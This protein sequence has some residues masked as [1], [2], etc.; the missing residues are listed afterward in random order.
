M[1][2]H[3]SPNARSIPD[4]PQALDA[5]CGSNRRRSSWRAHVSAAKTELDARTN[6]EA[7]RSQRHNKIFVDS[8]LGGVAAVFPSLRSISILCVVA[9]SARLN[10]GV[11]RGSVYRDWVMFSSEVCSL[12]AFVCHDSPAY[13]GSRLICF[14][15]TE[16]EV[17]SVSCRGEGLVRMRVLFC[18]RANSGSCPMQT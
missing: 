8:F 18:A 13:S 6:R 16:W 1:D 10:L 12:R 5:V 2:E 15:P 9:S 4:V 11:V 14:S 17:W 3:Q 7:E